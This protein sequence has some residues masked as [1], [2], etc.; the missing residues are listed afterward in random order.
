MVK[1]EW[2][3]LTEEEQNGP[4]MEVELKP[5]DPELAEERRGRLLDALCRIDQ[6]LAYEEAIHYR[7]KGA[8][9]A[10]E[11]LKKKGQESRERVERAYNEMLEVKPEHAGK[12][13][14]DIAVL[15]SKTLGLSPET[16]RK[17]LP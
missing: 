4:S 8:A 1:S 6:M 11:G 17:Y 10:T 7:N 16:I 15:L 9:A 13:K 2:I 3:P 5:V 12:K 14:R